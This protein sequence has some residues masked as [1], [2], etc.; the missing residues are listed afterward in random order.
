MHEFS[1]HPSAR[2]CS[3][4]AILSFVFAGCSSPAAPGPATTGPPTPELPPPVQAATLSGNVVEPGG[5]RLLPVVSVNAWVQQASGAAYSY[6]YIN[7]PRYTDATGQYEMPNLPIGATVYLDF[8]KDGYVQQCA[9]EITISGT[10]QRDVLLVPKASLSATTAPVPPMPGFRQVSGV[11][12]EAATQGGVQGRQPA[13]NVG[14]VYN[15]GPDFD[16][17]ET[18]TDG[19]GRFLLCGLSQAR[20]LQ[21][22]GYGGNR[23]AYVSV[24]PGP[25]TTIELDLK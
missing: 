2:F 10:T 13:A 20:T 17:G 6:W 11:V 5:Q 23:A 15:A 25:D 19:Q 12:Y 3:P 16:A 24:P 4:I 9:V 8:K 1:K 7:G 14:V 18:V 21:I 22:V